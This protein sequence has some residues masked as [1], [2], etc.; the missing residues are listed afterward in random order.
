MFELAKHPDIQRKVQDEIDQVLSETDDGEFTYDNLSKLKYL[1]CC[2]DE[3]LR[4]YPIVPV[5]FR[6]ATRDYEIKESGL[7]IPKGTGIFIPVMGIQRD[8]EVYDDPMEFIPERF[9][10]SST[11]GGKVEGVYYMPFGDGPRNCIGMRLGKLTTKIGLA[12]ILQKFSVAH[13]NKEFLTSELDFH[14]AVF[15][16][17]PTKPFNLE[18][19]LR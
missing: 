13:T 1:E 16:L 10:N 6:T 5:H 19:S 7:T 18:I 14:P 17:T 3:A 12:L 2:I 4:K 9:L 8:P 15:V 11:G